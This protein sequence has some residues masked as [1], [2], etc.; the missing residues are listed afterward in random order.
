MNILWQPGITMEEV[1]IQAV[2]H[3]MMFFSNN[4]VAAAESLDIAVRTIDNLLANEK[5]KDIK[6]DS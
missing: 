2:K 5:V 6:A 4:K 1:K 3:A